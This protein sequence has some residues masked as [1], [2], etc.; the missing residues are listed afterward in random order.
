[1]NRVVLLPMALLLSG[2]TYMPM[3]RI[4]I[5]DT[6]SPAVQGAFLDAAETWFLAVPSARVP[7]SIGSPANVMATD[8]ETD[9]ECKKHAAYTLQ[10]PTEAPVIRVCNPDRYKP[11]NLKWLALHELGHALS[12]R[13][14]HLGEGNVM[15]EDIESGERTLFPTAADIDYVEAR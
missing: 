6:L 3:D 10:S 13:G 1:M 14:D 2:C 4:V 9:P 12:G 8:R 11:N 7:V 15:V 5:D